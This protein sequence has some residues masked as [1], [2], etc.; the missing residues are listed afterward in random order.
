MNAL[1][2]AISQNA[3]L[4]TVVS[5]VFSMEMMLVIFLVVFFTFVS[6]SRVQGLVKGRKFRI[7]ALLLLIPACIAGGGMNLARLLVSTYSVPT[8]TEVLRIYYQKPQCIGLIGNGVRAELDLAE[9]NDEP[10][11]PTRYADVGDEGSPCYLAQP[12][13]GM[14]SK[15]RQS[16]LREA[17]LS[18]LSGTRH[19]EI[20]EQNPEVRIN[21]IRAYKRYGTI[22][23][24]SPE[25]FDAV[26]PVSCYPRNFFVPV[27]AIVYS[28]DYTKFKRQNLFLQPWSPAPARIKITHENQYLCIGV[29]IKKNGK[30]TT[31][32]FSGGTIKVLEG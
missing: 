5:R 8:I 29:S 22:R 30:S 11:L 13:L 3:R 32:L 28:P 14:E 27:T 9:Y 20:V 23:I 19:L 17:A 10:W 21:G 16:I 15:D 31:F 2:S 25:G 1:V 18:F 7:G 4:M 26:T 12:E 24:D 6:R